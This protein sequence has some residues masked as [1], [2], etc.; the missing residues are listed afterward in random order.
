MKEETQPK[1][2][3]VL[4][5]TSNSRLFRS[6]LIGYLYEISQVYP[7]ILLSEKL[8]SQTEE[9]IRNKKLFPKLEKIV[10]TYQRAGEKMNL[11][12]RHKYFSKLA[13]D[14][15]QHYKP[16]IVI[17]T[18]NNFFEVYLRRFASRI[19]AVNIY[20]VEFLFA[21]T[22]QAII[23]YIL[24]I[25]Y[26]KAPRFLPQ[27][28]K[29]LF[30]KF[31]RH[32]GH[33]LC[34]WILPPLNG[35]RPFVKEPSFVLAADNSRSGGIDYFF[36]FS[37]KDY[38]ILI[39]DGVPAEKIYILVHPLARGIKARRFFKK[40]Y[41]SNPLNKNKIYT[42]ILTVM[43]P[44]EPIGFKRDSYSLI[45]K[46]GLLKS[47]T[48]IITL[49]TKILKEWKIFIK[50]HPLTENVSELIQTFKSI[51]NQIEVVKPAESTDEYIEKSDA[52]LGLS[53][54][55]TTLF[56]ASLQC[57][58]KPILSLDLQCEFCGDSYKNFNGVEYI[59]N[60]ERFI[61]ILRLI[62]DNKYQ[63]KYQKNKEGKLGPREFSNTIELL[64]YLFNKKIY[65]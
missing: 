39:K 18:G 9:I 51:S 23:E 65:G 58:E 14:I 21:Q 43:W 54:A 42:K 36:V 27:W 37:R 13:K 2:K 52:I 48:E 5:Y 3:K 53:P 40:I 15:I 11:F 6:T 63:K 26:L 29:I 57:P 22:K 30:S 62:R 61:H 7:V 19:N 31:R 20:F 56:T 8:D 50:P 1:I 55:S 4:F 47:R 35:Q 49:I 17:T 41:S 44:P 59:N 28:G 24:R 46:E 45:S 60:E 32:L 12:T 16:D 25:A 64:K 10:P 33:F 38:D 34:F